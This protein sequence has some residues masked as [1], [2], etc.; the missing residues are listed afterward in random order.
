MSS[1]NALQILLSLGEVSHGGEWQNYLELG[2]SEKDQ[3]NLLLLVGNEA[4]HEADVDSNEVWVPLHA[5]RALGQIGNAESV[6]PLLQ[7]FDVLVKDDWAIEELPLVMGMIGEPSIEPLAGYLCDSFH[8]EFARSMAADG[9]KEVAVNFPA[10]RERVV[11]VLTDYLVSADSDAVILNGLVVC[12]LVDLEAVESIAVIRQLY[13]TGCVDISCTGDLEDVEIALGLRDERTTPKPDYGAFHEPRLHASLLNTPAES[14]DNNLFDEVDEFLMHHG[15][16]DAILNVSELDGFFTAVV[17]APQTILPSQWMPAIWGGE[18]QAPEWP[19]QQQ[20][21]KFISAAMVIYN[22]VA[23]SLVDDTFQALFM[24][25]EVKGKLYTV[26]DEWCAGFLRGIKLWGPLSSADDMVV[27]A[28]LQPMRLFAAEDADWESLD[29]MDEQEIES[30]QQ[31]VENNALKL[32]RHFLQ[33]RTPHREPMRA[34]P[35][36]GRNDPCPCGSGKKFKK[37]CLH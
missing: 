33:R 18:S 24:E 36:P 7:L 35:L 14:D 25:R 34:E 27:E 16:D 20:A 2:I 6:E 32:Y 13:Q 8:D 11:Q 37:C 21:H 12:C 28:A 4:L 22:Q 5:W 10:C 3:M 31:E 26:V 15:G 17:S 9:L 19:D 1:K 30:L 23:Q 29:A